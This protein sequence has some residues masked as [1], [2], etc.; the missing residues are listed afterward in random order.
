MKKTLFMMLRPPEG[1][2][3]PILAK[4]GSGS[5]ILLLEDAILGAI[6]KD[7]L[8]ELENTGMTLYA[9][10]ESVTARGFMAGFPGNV[11]LVSPA[12]LPRL[13]MEEYETSITL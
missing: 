11:E 12:D 5:G 9:L 6:R 3:P 2:L 4:Y 13:I 7:T 1:D 8:R 10:R